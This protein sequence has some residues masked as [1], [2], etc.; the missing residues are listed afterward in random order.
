MIGSLISAKFTVAGGETITLTN[1][2]SGNV[3]PGVAVSEQTYNSGWPTIT[4]GNPS[5]VFNATVADELAGKVIQGNKVT[6]IEW[7][8]GG[9]GTDIDPA[10]MVITGTTSTLT[11]S[12]SFGYVV[13]A[14][15][16]PADNSNSEPSTTTISIKASA[17]PATGAAPAVNH[18]WGTAAP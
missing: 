11:V 8:F 2:I 15:E 1:I 17:D 5:L 9:V 18:V 16:V 13:D 14:L 10:T 7:V 4:L 12:S 6:A 3:T